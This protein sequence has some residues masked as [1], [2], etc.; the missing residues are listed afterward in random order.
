MISRVSA[1]LVRRADPV[2]F[3][4][5]AQIGKYVF[6]MI[7]NPSYFNWP[8]DTLLR[9]LVQ[10]QTLVVEVKGRVVSFL[11]Y[12]DLVDAF[13]ISVLATQPAAQ[14]SHYQIQLILH[15]QELA[16]KQR[17]NLI[18][19]V[20]SENIKALSLYQKMGFDLIYTRKCYYADKANALVMGWKSDKAG[21]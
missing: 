9:E 17:A 15:L 20:H 2:D 7:S 11:C 19:E 18:L 6:E 13:E 14:K 8:T 21:C 3:E 16:A 1:G 5:I 12:R 4:T 10:V